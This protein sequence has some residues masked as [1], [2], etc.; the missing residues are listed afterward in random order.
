MTILLDMQ[1]IKLRDSKNYSN[2]IKKGHHKWDRT[3]RTD[4]YKYHGKNFKWK[5]KDK[6]CIICGKRKKHHHKYCDNCH[7]RL[8]KEG[9]KNLR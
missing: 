5:Y 6:K 2:M 1:K 9:K 8:I 4:A 3:N 7:N